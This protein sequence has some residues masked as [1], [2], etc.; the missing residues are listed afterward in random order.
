VNG[1]TKAVFVGYVRLDT[2]ALESYV[3]KLNFGATGK[4]Y[5]IDGTGTV[6]AASDPAQIGHPLPFAQATHD[7]VGGRSAGFLDKRSNDVVSVAP[8]N[9]G[10][11][12]GVTDQSATE[13]YGPLRSGKLRVEL[14]IVGMLVMAGLIVLVFNHRRESAR[15]RF[16]EQLAFQAAHDGLTGLYNR[17]VFHERLAQALARA[18]RLGT[19]VAVLYLDLDLFKPVNDHMGHEAG[20][21]VLAEVASRLSSIVRASDTVARMGGDEF[22]ILLEDA[23]GHEAVSSVARRIVSDLASPVVLRRGDTTIGVSVGIAYSVGGFGQAE[24][25]VR[26]ADLAMYRAKDAG[27]DRFEWAAAPTAQPV[28]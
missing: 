10:G 6:V 28:G 5:V 7:A 1:V 13:F 18:R 21:A 8:F 9:L 2:S 20:D 17:S 12:G 26:D 25:I 11:W 16:Q 15:R 27:G 24:P 22:A 19:D 23:A 14:A 3:R 4:A